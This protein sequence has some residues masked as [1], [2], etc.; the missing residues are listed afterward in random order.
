MTPAVIDAAALAV[1][2]RIT[3]D[4]AR[5]WLRE[6]APAGLPH[7]QRGRRRW[8]TEAWLAEWMASNLRNQPRIQGTSPLDEKLVE[9]AAWM[10]GE[11]VKQG[12]LAV[13]P[14]A[15]MKGAA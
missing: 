11:L 10:V 3:K 7:V 6:P 5:R 14:M 12:R 9:R 8:T 15:D 2:F 1:R 4:Q 13:L